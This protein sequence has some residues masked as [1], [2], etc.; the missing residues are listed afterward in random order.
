MDQLR[1]LLY[2]EKIPY[3]LL[4]AYSA[5]ELLSLGTSKGYTENWARDAVLITAKAAVDTVNELSKMYPEHLVQKAMIGRVLRGVLWT[6]HNGGAPGTR[7]WRVDL[8]SHL[9]EVEDRSLECSLSSK[10]LKS[11]DIIYIS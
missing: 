4:K 8:W 10:W 5:I 7:S 3:R 9:D 6:I 11:K 1:K 2:G